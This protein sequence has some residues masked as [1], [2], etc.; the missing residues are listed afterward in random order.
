M[1]GGVTGPCAIKS[2]KREQLILDILNIKVTYRP[3]FCS[4][5]VSVGL[6]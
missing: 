4:V 1:G 2:F 6:S 5:P 3:G